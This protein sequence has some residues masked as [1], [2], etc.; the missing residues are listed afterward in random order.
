MNAIG[1]RKTDRMLYGYRMISSPGIMKVNPTT[2]ASK[3]MGNPEGLPPSNSYAAGDVSPDGAT[4]YLY[5]SRSGVLWKVNLKT[6]QASSV[7][8]SSPISLLDLAASPTDGNLYGV[9]R[10]GKL[11]RVN[12][13]TGQVTV[14]SVVGLE[15][16]GYGATWFTANGDLI[17]YENG[18]SK[19]N[20]TLNFIGSP[21]TTKPRLLTM[22]AGP[23][24][25]GNDGAAN[26]APPRWAGL[27]VEVDVL[28]ND[29]DPDGALDR[30]TLRIVQPPAKGTV[31]INAD[32]TITYT[33]G[34]SYRGT[35]SLRYE[36]CDN[37]EPRQCGTATVNI[38]SATIT[39]STS[40]TASRKE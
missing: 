8:L 14:R 40:P 38:T 12:P 19:P 25:V 13:R 34:S 11:L 2:G 6:F 4:Y 30:N 3:Y 27:S 35:D 9:D 22:Q 39:S 29:G 1:Y 23:S 15:P 21:T 24:T 31:R 18:T 17:A 5:T 28:A 20:G 10:S 33:S 37:G 7:K 26:T 32:K 16:G 36:V